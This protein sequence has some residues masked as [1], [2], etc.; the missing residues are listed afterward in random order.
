[1]LAW[2]RPVYV[3]PPVTSANRVHNASVVSFAAPKSHIIIIRKFHISW[4]RLRD[5]AGQERYRSLAPL[6][7]RGAHAAAIVYDITS[8]ETFVKAQFWIQELQMHAGPDI[9]ESQESFPCSFKNSKD[10]V[11]LDNVDR[12]RARVG[13]YMLSRTDLLYRLQ[14][15]TVRKLCRVCAL[16]N[17]FSRSHLQ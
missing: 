10:P 16:W 1:M 5:T 3:S 9:G 11:L 13:M 12:A 7:Y 4:M 6:Y 14:E 8:R 2:A 15:T 17:D